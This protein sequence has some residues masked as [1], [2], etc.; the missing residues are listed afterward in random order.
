M[1]SSG[2][3][4]LLRIFSGSDDKVGHTPLYEFIVYEA[5]KYGLAGAT[6]FRGVMGFGANSVVH[7]SKILAIS[8]DMPIVI[9][10]VD[11][12]GKIDGF[13]SSMEPHFGNSKFGLL[14]TTENVDVIKYSPAK[15]D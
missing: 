11:D 12:A 9:E 13:L 8:D 4:T 5:K 2:K 6:V 3:A 1:K 10:I 15:K 14:I 7:A